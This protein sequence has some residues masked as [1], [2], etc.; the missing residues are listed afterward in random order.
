MDHKKQFDRDGD[1]ITCDCCHYPG[2]VAVYR[3]TMVSKLHHGQEQKDI[4]FCEVCAS[5]L[6][7]ISHKYP[8][9]CS[10]PKLHQSIAYIGNMILD[11]IE[12]RSD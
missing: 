3:D 6:L 10:D 9:Q 8:D 7:S 4:T 1:P 2:K 12:N 5:T 11:A